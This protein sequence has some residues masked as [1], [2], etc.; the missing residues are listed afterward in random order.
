MATLLLAATGSA[1]GGM[2]G[3]TVL[4]LS[5]ATIGQAVGATLGSLIDQR[6]VGGGSSTVETGRLDTFRLSGA[7]AGTP[8]PYLAGRMRLPGQM[9]WS[10]RFRE[11]VTRDTQT[12]GGGGKGRSRPKV[13]QTT[14][15]YSYSVSFALALCEGEI[16]RVG[17]VWADGKILPRSAYSMRVH[18]GREDQVPDPL[19]AAVE[20]YANAPAYRGTAYA[21]FEELQLE[22]FGN[23]IPQITME[24]FRQPESGDETPIREGI[25]A[26]ALLPGAGEYALANAAVNLELG[27]GSYR[28]TNVNNYDG[29][30][31]AAVSLEN[32]S[33]QMP[34]LASTLLVVSWFGTDLRAEHCDVVPGVE[35]KASDGARMPWMVSGIGRGAAYDIS[36]TDGRVSYG[37]TPSDASVL[38]AIW[39]IH[40]HGK[41]VTFYPFILM[42]I[43]SGNGRTD[44]YGGV[45]Q[46]AFPWRGRITSDLDGTAAVIGAVNAFFGGA[47]VSDFSPHT[48][49]VSYSGPADGGYRRMVLHYAW[50]CAVAGGVQAFCIGSE[51]RGLTTLRASDGSYPAVAALRQLAGEVRSILGPGVKISYAADW[52]EYFGHHP[53]DGSGDVFYHLDPL[54]ADSNID[55]VG[56]DNY[57]PLSDWRDGEGHLDAEAGWRSIHDP[58][59]LS[60]NI[61]GG[62]GFDWYYA[63]DVDRAAQNRTPITDGAYGD[64]HVFRYK[65]LRNWWGRPHF[66]RPGGVRNDLQTAWEPRS[67]P[68]WFTEIGCPA[69]DK[70]TNQPNVF[71]DAK[72]T[73]SARPYFSTGARDDLIQHQYVKVM[74]EYWDAPGRNPVSEIYDGP[75]LETARSHVWAWDLRPWPDFPNRTSVWSDGPN[76]NRGHWLNGRIEQAPLPDLVREICARSGVTDIDVSAL[77]GVVPGM[78]LRDGQSARAALQ[79]LMTTFG[80]DCRERN[81]TLVFFMRTGRRDADLEGRDTVLR[82]NSAGPKLVRDGVSESADRVRLRYFNGDDSYQR[83]S[84]EAIRGANVPMRATG[85]DL[86]LALSQAMAESAAER[87]LF[88]G[89]VSRDG[90]EIV[91]PPSLLA[92][93]AGDVVGLANEN[94]RIDRIEDGLD[95]RIEFRRTDPALFVSRPRDERLFDTGAGA[96]V[97]SPLVHV[98]DLPLLTGEE[99]PHAPHIAAASDPWPG[100]INV[101]MS[102]TDDGFA[103]NTQLS[104][105][106]TVGVL[107]TP[108]V[109]SRAGVW[110]SG[111]RIRVSHGVL[112]S[113]DRAA[114]LNGANA[115]AIRFGGV[116]DWEVF[117]FANAAL[118]ANGLWEIGDLLRGQAGTEPLIPESWPVGSD[119]VV[120][121]GALEQINLG[122]SARTLTRKL[123]VGPAALGYDDPTYLSIEQAWDGVGLRPYAPVH[124]QARVAGGDLDLKWV[125]RTRVDGDLWTAGEV[126]L[127]EEQERYDVRLIKDGA[128]VW[129]AE[130]DAPQVTVPQENL[131]PAPYEIEV[132]QIS[133]RFGIGL[134]A[135]MT[136]ND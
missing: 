16:T 43:P 86:P 108:L 71:L 135:R 44:P 41:G 38:E 129:S 106:A 103:F 23:R 63:S 8:L 25:K 45:E 77:Y 55:F 95:R 48:T 31:D 19:I 68:I 109:R 89:E 93:E 101:F 75:M 61:E 7:Q 115:M 65:D 33:R 42:D 1:V 21:V 39:Q 117:Q 133:A 132:G 131:P 119:V 127:S 82:D 66:D 60:A 136:R 51:L 52:S 56:I 58:D 50:L 114:V 11:T 96:T 26:V 35:Q 116:G 128:V 110:S 13:T 57:M 126:P 118:V 85:S 10:T 83:G 54:W 37:G 124:L 47:Q 134:K 59:Y 9:I 107:D 120:L 64:H 130:T 104:E 27:P 87:W 17:R 123:R 80:F 30:A 88:E 98:L 14:V 20:G 113:R 73:E 32:M 72:S 94:W 24:V 67:K 40:T 4:G 100:A 36:R 49:G 12:Q 81:G 102:S 2:F 70:G 112:Q 105:T 74:T 122:I 79:P 92:L 78:E 69:I 15:T 76:Y 5:G 84:A 22:R 46:G 6:M 90:G 62:E 3:G 99:V 91:L 111:C 29:R 53:G 18:T 125:R 97:A 34:N 28:S 121:D